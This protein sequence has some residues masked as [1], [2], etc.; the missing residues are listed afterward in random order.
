[1][2]DKNERMLD[3]LLDGA[4]NEYSQVEPRVGLEN[5]ILATLSSNAQQESQWSWNRWQLWTAAA[6]LACV[7]IA[8]LA[9]NSQQNSV[10]AVVKEFL[11]PKNAKTSSVATVSKRPNPT[12]RRAPKWTRPR[13]AAKIPE[14]V[15]AAVKQPVFP[16]PSPLSQQ[17]Q[18]LFAYLRTTPYQELVQNSKPDEPRV[19][20]ELN[21]AIPWQDKSSDRNTNSQ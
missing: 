1:M 19:E 14:A 21:Q 15:T 7:V 4:L 3:E 13:T 12:V 18:L 16:S 5:R 11:T 20:L 8:V 9:L 10:P 2:P 6:A 17:E